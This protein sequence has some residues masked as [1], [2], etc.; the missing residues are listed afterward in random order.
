[1]KK[2]SVVIPTLNRSAMLDRLLTSIA[3]QSLLPAEVIVV[4]DCSDNQEKNL[5]VIS[6]HR[7]HL[8][9]HYMVNDKRSGAPVSRNRGILKA[10]SDYIALVDD[11]DEWLEDKLQEQVELFESSETNLGLVYTWTDVVN[12]NR[13]KISENYSTISGHAKSEILSDCFIS[14]PS[15]MVKKKAIMDA[16][17]FD[18]SFVS[19]QDWDTWTRIIFKGYS[20]KP[21]KKVLTLYYKH[22]GPTI[23]TSPRA[24]TGYK[25]YY[26]KHFLKLIVY[27][28][29]RHIIRFL[30]LTFN[31]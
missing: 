3:R 25:Q 17:L 19:C 8:N 6:K 24:K 14:S 22:D 5:A 13:E 15:V 26:R 11:D 12:S 23:G 1:M 21:V 31:L 10:Q 18:E 2:V 7:E 30:R 29:F 16:G 9:L 4:D 27:G 28:K 20:A